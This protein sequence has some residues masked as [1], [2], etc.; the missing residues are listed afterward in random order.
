VWRPC[1]Q[2]ETAVAWKSAIERCDGPTSLLLTRQNLPAQAGGAERSELAARGGYVLADAPGG[3]PDIV[4][5]ATGSEVALAMKAK[6]TLAACG[7][8]AR[9][10]SMPCTSVFDAQDA[11]Y[12]CSVLPDRV[13]RVAIEAGVSD[14][15]RKYVGLE[16][17]VVGLDRFGES[18]PAAVLFEHFGFT[19]DHVADVA[20]AVLAPSFVR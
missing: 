5:I 17:G 6:E 9:V 2:L 11:A 13:R 3:K 1:D 7:I 14:P 4:L 16:G 10:V 12:R 19:A 15:W 8:A 18:A 20:A